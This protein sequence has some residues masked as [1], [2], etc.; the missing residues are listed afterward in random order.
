MTAGTPLPTCAGTRSQ[1][2]LQR[3]GAAGALLALLIL[4]ASMLLRLATV[5]DAQ[6]HASSTLPALVEQSARLLHRLSAS[7][8]ALLAL[9]AVLLCWQC[10]RVAPHWVRPTAWVVACTVVLAVIGPLT[11]GYRSGA[12]TVLNVSGGLLLLMSFWW[13]REAAGLGLTRPAALDRFSW[14][15]LAALLLQVASGASASAW[16]M[17][18]LRWPAYLHMASVVL[19]LIL[20]GVVLFDQRH[21]PWQYR[22][23]VAV[24]GLLLSQLLAG[25]LLMAQDSRPLGL[26][27]LHALLAPLLA[28]ALVSLIK[29][30]AG[31]SQPCADQ[32]P[33]T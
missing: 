12:V 7:G 9:W 13:L 6:G 14:A 16:A 32:P 20:C 5:F 2:R 25:Y 1:H 29:H 27:V 21:K 30:E 15:A 23:A 33:P 26:S 8:V 28:C 31:A 19:V 4:A 3:I 17:Q 22:R 18:G 10:R 11:S 24:A